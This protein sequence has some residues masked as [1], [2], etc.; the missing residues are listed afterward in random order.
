MTTT[1]A[2]TATRITRA[3]RSIWPAGVRVSTK[4]HDRSIEITAPDNLH[5][6]SGY[7]HVRRA[8]I[9]ATGRLWVFNDREKIANRGNGRFARYHLYAPERPLNDRIVGAEWYDRQDR[10]IVRGDVVDENTKRIFVKWQNGRVEQIGRRARN[11]ELDRGEF[12]WVFATDFDA[13]AYAAT[14][15]PTHAEDG[16]ISDQALTDLRLLYDADHLT[17]GFTYDGRGLTDWCMDELRI[18]GYADLD[19]RNQQWRIT[20]A[21]IEKINRLDGVTELA[22]AYRRT[23]SDDVTVIVLLSNNWV[24]IHTQFCDDPTPSREREHFRAES[25]AADEFDRRVA[26]VN[27]AR[28]QAENADQLGDVV[29][30]TAGQVDA[31]QHYTVL[32]TRDHRVQRDV[33]R[34]DGTLVSSDVRQ[35][36][37]ADE[38]ALHFKAITSVDPL[39]LAAATTVVGLTGSQQRA[40]T[41]L[42]QENTTLADLAAA[43]VHRAELETLIAFGLVVTG[44]GRRVQ[45]STAGIRS[46]RAANPGAIRPTITAVHVAA[47]AKN[48]PPPARERFDNA[49]ASLAATGIKFVMYTGEGM[50]RGD[51]W[52]DAEEKH[53]TEI[54]FTVVRGGHWVDGDLYARNVDTVKDYR[55][56]YRV[57]TIVISFHY[58]RPDVARS[59]VK[60]FTEAGLTATW[61]DESF[62]MVTKPGVLAYSNAVEVHLA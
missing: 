40:L 37:T 21:G 31:G 49:V 19:V 59:I 26:A 61:D 4:V 57:D 29:S 13:A 62:E 41:T 11:G 18:A 2:A 53:G 25:A 27:P 55:E 60:A 30:M 48:Q 1:H 28:E 8:V 23:A 56:P 15:E 39:V 38:A 5:G 24:E 10:E 43:G 6:A 45:I 20:D 3:L 47:L 44:R 9:V 33:F 34:T 35:Y 32:L 36:A 22:R 51:A 7:E 52:C 16:R 14:D 46:L 50:T 54:A 12:R 17:I 42:L 58:N